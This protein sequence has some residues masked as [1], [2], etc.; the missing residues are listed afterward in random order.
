M[1]RIFGKLYVQVFIA[2]ILGAIVGVF[3][4]ETGTALKPLGDAFIK[5]I[6]MHLAL[7]IFLTVVTGIARMENMK[8][9]GRVGFR[10]LI[11]FEVVS[12]LATFGSLL[13]LGKLMACV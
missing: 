9:L 10:A 2:V 5:L 8:E 13:S 4:P 7:V 3:V 11:Y 12:S 6:K 1:K